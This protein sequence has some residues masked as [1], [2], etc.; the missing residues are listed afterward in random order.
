MIVVNLAFLK[1]GIVHGSV[2]LESNSLI[3]KRIVIEN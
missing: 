2:E 1:S 3:N